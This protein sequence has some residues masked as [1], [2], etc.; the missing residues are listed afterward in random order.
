MTTADRGTARE[1]V[2][3][4]Y[5]RVWQAGDAW[6]LESSDFEQARYDRQLALLA[7]RRYERALELGCGSGGFTRRLAG[8]ADRV[9]ALDVAAAAIDRARAATVGAGPGV[10][11]FRVADVMDYDPAP[12]GPWDLI[13]LSETIYCV[14]WLY[15]FFDVAWMADRLFAATRPGEQ[16]LLANTYGREHKDWL[17]RPWLV[18]T[19]R[20]LFRNVGF[21]VEAEEVFRGAKSGVE[22]RVLMSLF[23]KPADGPPAGA[24]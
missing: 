2:R 1:T 14:G 18:N 12:E 8:V 20:D 17:I 4:H 22:I 21:R 7:G 3:A 6:E 9:V 23:V 19:Y 15:P 11:E 13:V 16:L 10:V 24:G 5:E